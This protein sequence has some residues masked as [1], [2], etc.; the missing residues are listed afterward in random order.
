MNKHF[1][2]VSFVAAYPHS[3]VRRV[4]CNSMLGVLNNNLISTADRIAEQLVGDKVNIVELEPRDIKA[5][6]AAVDDQGDV[7]L[8]QA[9]RVK[10]LQAEF[11]EIHKRT[12]SRS[13]ADLTTT[14]RVRSLAD[15]VRLARDPEKDKAP[16]GSLERALADAAGAQQAQEVKDIANKRKQLASVGLVATDTMIAN[17]REETRL[18]N[19]AYADR[20]A[21]RMG[22]ITWVIDHMFAAPKGEAWN[23]FT[24]DERQFFVDKAV[25]AMN[26]VENTVTR[27]VLSGRSGDDVLGIGDLLLV[28]DAQ[29][30]LVKLA[31]APDAVKPKA[32]RPNKMQVVKKD[33]SVQKLKDA[34][35]RKATAALT[36]DISTPNLVRRTNKVVEKLQAEANGVT[37]A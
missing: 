4:I 29:A 15:A 13:L 11:F 28:R 37:T 20:R 21:Q 12:A 10:A 17:M 6:M 19:Q 31:S 22:Y 16:W 35:A 7:S 1:N 32:P 30:Q 33:G 34:R 2:L 23:S 36:G 25:A 3:C 18:R 14:H 8:Q 9:G 5:I 27:N 26:N 24:M